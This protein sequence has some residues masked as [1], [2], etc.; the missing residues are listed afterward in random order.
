MV[1]C[2]LVL[3]AAGPLGALIVPRWGWGMPA[4]CRPGVST[5]VIWLASAVLLAVATVTALAL[6]DPPTFRHL[7]LFRATG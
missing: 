3:L 1:C 4:C 5:L 2:L 7:C 6:L